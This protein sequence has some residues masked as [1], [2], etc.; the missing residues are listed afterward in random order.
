LHPDFEYSNTTIS[1]SNIKCMFEFNITGYKTSTLINLKHF[2]VLQKYLLKHPTL[3]LALLYFRWRIMS[4]TAWNQVMG[5]TEYKLLADDFINCH[6]TVKHNSITWIFQLQLWL[7]N[8]SSGTTD[9]TII[10]SQTVKLNAYWELMIILL[11]SRKKSLSTL[12]KVLRSDKFTFQIILTNIPFSLWGKTR[13]NV[14]L[15][16]VIC[17]LR[18]QNLHSFG[19]RRFQC[20]G[21]WCCVT[22]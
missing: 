16:Y 6:T 3:F 11:V 21:M 5:I 18:Q 8:I 22:E 20:F 10:C 1:L 4:L 2:C 17:S 9:I 14:T 15:Q 19:T 12:Q 13:A 7:W